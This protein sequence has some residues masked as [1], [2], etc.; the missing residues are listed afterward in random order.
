MSESSSYSGSTNLKSVSSTDSFINRNSIVL[1][2][3]G[4]LFYLF[5]RIFIYYIILMII[6]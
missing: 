2:D 4:K 5:K 3:S 1:K 6:N